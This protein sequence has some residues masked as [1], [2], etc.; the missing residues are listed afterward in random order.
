MRNLI[1]LFLTVFIVAC[2]G[3]DDSS[4]DSSDGGGDGGGDGDQT[5]NNNGGG[6]SGAFPPPYQVIDPDPGKDD[7]H[8]FTENFGD[9]VNEIQK[10]TKK[11]YGK[12]MDAF[13]GPQLLMIDETDKFE[14]KFETQMTKLMNLKDT[15]DMSP[16]SFMDYKDSFNAIDRIYNTSISAF[17]AKTGLAY[18]KG[19]RK[20]RSEERISR[21]GDKDI[22]FGMLRQEGQNLIAMYML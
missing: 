7:Y 13:K 1:Y 6:G 19:S 20:K 4:D 9:Y 22:K 3:S 17:E 5:S 8:D 18:D 21:I 15:Y 11:Y 12:L 14:E 16:P 2:S 10:K